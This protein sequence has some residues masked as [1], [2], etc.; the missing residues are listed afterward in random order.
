MG[1]GAVVAPTMPELLA[2]LIPDIA[3]D[4]LERLAH[5]HPAD[6]F[7]FGAARAAQAAMAAH[8]REREETHSA[9][10]EF[11]QRLKEHTHA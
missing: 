1:A 7:A 8:E 3:Q 11:I 2:Q 6:A 9:V 5:M 10:N 4:D